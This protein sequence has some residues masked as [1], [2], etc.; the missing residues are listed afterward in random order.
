MRLNAAKKEGGCFRPILSIESPHHRC[1]PVA[2]HSFTR[3]LRFMIQSLLRHNSVI[4]CSA[5]YLQA[6]QDL[7][8]ERDRAAW[9]SSTPFMLLSTELTGPLGPS[10]NHFIVGYGTQLCLP[11]RSNNFADKISLK[12]KRMQCGAARLPFQVLHSIRTIRT[13]KAR[14]MSA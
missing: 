7:F 11:Q 9:Q 12:T 2:L 10:T 14:G 4:I 8:I 3:W 13:S 6:N 5:S 1:L